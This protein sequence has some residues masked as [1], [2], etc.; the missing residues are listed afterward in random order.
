MK[1]AIFSADFDRTYGTGNITYEYCMALYKKNIDFVLFLPDI[2]AEGRT[3]LREDMPFKIN[4]ILP[5][6]VLSFSDSN[7]SKLVV[8]QWYIW[9]YFKTIDL[10]EFTLVHCL[11]EYP[12]SFIAARCAK[13][14]KLPFIING[15][16]TY[17]VAPLVQWP[18]KYLLKY[19]YNQSREIIVISQFTKNKIKEY[20]KKNYNI[21]IIH[22]GVNFYRFEN[23]PDISESKNKYNGQKILL[24]VGKLIPRKGHDLVIKTIAKIKDRYPNIKYLIIGDGKHEGVLKNLV[25]DLGL[26]EKV[27]FLGRVSDN[28]IIKYFHLCDIYVHTPKFSTDLKFEGFGIVYL[29]ASACGKPIVASDAGGVRDAVVDGQ[30]GLIAKNEDIDDIASKI[31]QLLDDDNLRK[32]MGEAGRV[33]AK[34]HDWP[35]IADKFID[36]YKKYSL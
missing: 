35:N 27:E 17:A 28:D 6:P 5:K 23:S 19:S 14:N 16:G 26:N 3:N 31:S 4:Y 33:Y 22:P 34:E 24:T 32:K 36:K 12:M 2:P 25:N 29:E 20:T 11:T 30:T 9:Q 10:S 8:W 13:K 18:A 15:Y 21:S 1:I 7:K